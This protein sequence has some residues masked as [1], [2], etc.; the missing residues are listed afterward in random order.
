MNYNYKANFWLW[1][2]YFFF[3][4]VSDR[5]LKNVLKKW[6]VKNWAALT[7]I[8]Q[9]TK[10]IPLKNTIHKYPYNFSWLRSTRISFFK[11]LHLMN[12]QT[13][14]IIFLSFIHNM[15]DLKW[16]F[17]SLKINETIDYWNAWEIN[18]QNYH[19]SFY[20]LLLNLIFMK[21]TNFKILKCILG[22]FKFFPPRGVDNRGVLQCFFLIKFVK[23]KD[24]KIRGW[25][26][27]K[28]VNV[29]VPNKYVYL[30]LLR[31]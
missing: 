22:F 18:F 26:N 16:F 11:K 15:N 9:N 27:S 20:L 21:N 2:L 14:G 28:N 4:I 8:Y 24:M 25:S 6:R 12:F 3:F 31:R 1:K 17:F 19:R 29:I 23:L 5:E 13:K 7:N 30:G 10:Y